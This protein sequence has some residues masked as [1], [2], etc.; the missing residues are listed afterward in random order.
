MAPTNVDA[1][2]VSGNPLSL[3]V[4]W[5]PPIFPNGR[6]THYNIYCEEATAG[7][8]GMSSHQEIFTSTVQGQEMNTMVTGL[9]PFTTYD[10]YVSANTSVGE[11]TRSVLVSGTTDEYGKS[12][13]IASNHMIAQYSCSV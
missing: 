4:V 5:D 10:C 2:A 1:F 9:T 8:G 7:S 6:L 12:T 13:D 3:N 11:G